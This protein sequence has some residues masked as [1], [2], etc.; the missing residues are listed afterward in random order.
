MALRNKECFGRLAC[1]YCIGL[2]VNS[3]KNGVYL[4]YMG[5]E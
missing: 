3:R 4:S 5:G 2:N 1:L